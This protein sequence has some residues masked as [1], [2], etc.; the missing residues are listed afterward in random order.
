MKITNL[1][2]IFIGILISIN[3][4]FQVKAQESTDYTWKPLKIGGG[5]WVVGMYIHPTEPNLR[6]VRTDVS[7][8]YRWDESAQK[9]KQIVTLESMP[10]SYVRYANYDGVNSLCGAPSN[11]DIA[12]MAFKNQVFRSA[13]RGDTWISTNYYGSG[14]P[15]MDSNGEGRQEGER[16]VVDPNNS[17]V[18]YYGGIS[19]GLWAT[20]DS[21]ESWLK[22]NNIPNG[23]S[24][25]GVNT[26]VFDKN[27]GTN[28]GRTNKIFVTVDGQG[29]YQSSDAGVNWTKISTF[30]S[31]RPR[32][33]EIG[34]DGTYYVACTNENADGSVWKYAGTQ[35]TNITPAGINNAYWDLA[36]DPTNAQ[37]IVVIKSGGGAWT[38][39][40]QGSSWTS[41]GSF[42]LVSTAVD[43]LAKQ[44]T[45]WLSVGEILFDPLESGKL[46]FAEGFGVWYTKDLTKTQ[47]TWTEQSAGI[48]ETCGNTVIAPPGGKAVSAMWDIGAFHHSNPDSYN[49]TRANDYFMSCWH[50][51][52]CP[53]DPQFIVGVFQTHLSYNQ[54]PRTSY[55]ADGGRSWTT[56]SA[57]PGGTTDYGFGCVA[58]SA[59]DINNIVRLPS[60]DKLPYYTKDKGKTWIPCTI[61]GITNSRYTAYASPMK[62]LCADRVDPGTFY[63]YQQDNGTYKSTDGG[64][65]WTKTSNGPVLKRYNSMMKTTPGKAKDIWFA[66]GKQ[67]TV[68][69]G[70][71]HSVD[72]GTTWTQMWTENSG[73][74]QVFSFGFG[75]AQATGAY[76]TIFAAGVANGEHGIYRSVD[77]GNTWTKIGV[78]PL[79]IYD[80]VDD[81]DGDKNEFG[82]VYVCF[83]GAGFAYGVEDKG[84]SGVIILKNEDKIN[85]SVSN[86]ILSVRDVDP[87]TTIQLYSISG[88][89]IYEAL[90][91]ESFTIS[92]R[93][94][95]SSVLLLC[96]SN[97]NMK[98][99]QKIII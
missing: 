81:M 20:Y 18:V 17:N 73:L 76:P 46:W 99:V 16:L 25:H 75:K 62:P 8:A 32:D 13:N 4:S 80:Y 82:K 24:S 95:Q 21:G 85:F 42:K 97:N 92:L 72:G 6:Y 56:F 68:A 41:Q 50:L 9:W 65:N 86:G 45:Y 87:K 28:N 11:P 30:S 48:E 14:T 40:N 61:S 29:V 47:I 51:D 43:W 2:L 70:L 83:A 36:V 90:H 58:I 10:E 39:L 60:N 94:Y 91:H 66:E 31:P 78:Y 77:S 59:T 63:F 12:Y 96:L 67:G 54:T 5:G 35:W 19:G 93:D 3:V 53:A 38:S 15:T 27:S 22:I 23:N 1:R 64:I 37:R 26:I 69:G 89:L 74:Q 49:A 33:A 71:W 84:G 52:W 44:D 34:S 55:S 79:G 7:G 57:Q 98:K 88:E